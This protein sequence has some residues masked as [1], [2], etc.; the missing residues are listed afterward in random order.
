MRLFDNSTL[1]SGIF[2]PATGIFH[3]QTATGGIQPGDRL[4]LW[5]QNLA[6]DFIAPAAPGGTVATVE[7]QFFAAGTGTT[8]SITVNGRVYSHVETNPS[9]ESSADQA[10]ALVAAINAGA[11][12]ADVVASIGSVSNAVDLAVQPAAGGQSIAVSAS[13]GNAAATLYQLSPASVAASLAQSINQYD[14][15]GAGLVNSIMA[16]AAADATITISAA[17]AGVVN[18]SGTTVTWISGTRFSG[19]H[20][21]DTIGLGANR[22]RRVDGRFAYAVDAD[23]DGSRPDRRKLSGAARRL[24]RQ[25]DHCS[26]VEQNQHAQHR[27]AI[28]QTCGRHLRWH[29][30]ACPID[31][32]ALG[33]DQL[34]Q[35]WL[36]FAP[37]LTDSAA[38]ADTEWSAT[39]SNWTVSDPNGKRPLKIAGPG[40]VRIGNADSAAHY[41]GTTWAIE[42]GFFFEDSARSPALPAIPSR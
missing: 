7:Y 31:F 11:G 40:S 38:Y 2:A 8:H 21:G 5:L 16:S 30:A 28:H 19:L 27:R 24:R 9:G 6:F 33:I 13:D 17:R 12:D 15:A 3:V 14:W 34:R 41:A 10:T 26:G 4:T 35:A 1:V 36:T 23:C 32:T 22:W 39:F 29:L 42:A 37:A 18:V 25:H 20:T